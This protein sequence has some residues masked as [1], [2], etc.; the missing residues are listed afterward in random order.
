MANYDKPF[1]VSKYLG[2]PVIANDDEFVVY[3]PD[4]RRIGAAKTTSG[5]RRIVKGY[6]KAS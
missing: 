1:S 2:Y 3:T 4:M 6:R 5:V